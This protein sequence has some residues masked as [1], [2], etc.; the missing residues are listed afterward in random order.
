MKK[1]I[2][3]LALILS[4]ISCNE[5]KKAKKILP[6]SNGRVNE[7]LVVIDET[8]WKGI[9]GDSI[10]AIVTAPVLGLPQPE[11]SFRVSQ[12][13]QK[14]FSSMFQAGRAILQVGI[15]KKENV[16]FQKDVY[17][18]PQRIV[19]VTATSK[20]ELIDLIVKNKKK[21]VDEFRNLGIETVQ[22]G[23]KDYY[24]FSGVKLFQSKGYHFKIP[25]TYRKVEDTEDFLWYRHRID[26]NG[27]SMEL[28]S[29]TMPINSKEDEE[30][31]T[32]IQNRDSIGEKYLRGETEDSYAITEKAYTPHIF[33]IKLNGK[34]A[35]ETRGK[36]EIKGPYMAAGS[37]VNY[38]VVDKKRNRLVVV[39][40]FVYAPGKNK[41]D[42]MFELE[43][44]AKTLQIDK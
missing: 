32:I 28:V 3:L 30:G 4:L 41:R 9:V 12:V 26:G 27:N 8:D 29:Y 37:F 22:R 10:R 7:L 21:I 40:G 15:S 14:A 13:S 17:A 16:S 36:W 24:P 38:T 39:E 33:P 23:F 44:V 43:A 19:T 42:Y 34:K 11:P 35:F 1:T 20:N 31:K 2:L 6:N 5:G 25:T 18:E